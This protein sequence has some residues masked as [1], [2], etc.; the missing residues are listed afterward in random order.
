MVVTVT[1]VVT[2]ET[3]NLLTSRVRRVV[4]EEEKSREQEKSRN[5]EQLHSELLSLY[6]KSVLELLLLDCNPSH[7]CVV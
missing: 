3:L 5:Q 7:R 4:W 2:I 6:D 1:M